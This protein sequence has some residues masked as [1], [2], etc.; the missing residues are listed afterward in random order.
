MAG[1]RSSAERLLHVVH[2]LRGDDAQMHWLAA[3]LQQLFGGEQP[4]V[5]STEWLHE[6][7]KRRIRAAFLTFVLHHLD[8]FSFQGQQQVIAVSGFLPAK[9]ASL[10]ASQCLQW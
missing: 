8:H 1:E 6:Q 10:V 4:R 3:A 5:F 2:Q 7:W 9:F